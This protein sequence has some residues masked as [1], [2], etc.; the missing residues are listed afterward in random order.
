LITEN[1]EIFGKQQDLQSIL[2]NIDNK[3]KD[4]D[5][6]DMDQFM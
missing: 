3:E 6:D 5:E 2:V 1:N 4:K